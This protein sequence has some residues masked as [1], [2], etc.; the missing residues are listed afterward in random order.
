MREE[1]ARTMHWKPSDSITECTRAQGCIV[2][3]LGGGRGRTQ[4]CTAVQ[5]SCSLAL[6]VNEASVCLYAKQAELWIISF[7]FFAPL[8]DELPHPL[9]TTLRPPEIDLHRMDT[10][11]KGKEGERG[12]SSESRAMCS[13]HVLHMHRPPTRT[14]VQR[15]ALGWILGCVNS[16]SCIPLGASSRNLHSIK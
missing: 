5:L 10:Q 15:L 1:S 8:L 2:G 6:K 16:G 9:P 13:S 14:Y 4:S 3:S 7:L 12:L 11:M